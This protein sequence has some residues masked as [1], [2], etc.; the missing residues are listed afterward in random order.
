M[1]VHLAPLGAAVLPDATPAALKYALC[2]LGLASP[3]VRLPL[4]ELDQPDKMTVAKAVAGVFLSCRGCDGEHH[5]LLA[6]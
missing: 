6:V 1:A 2:L 3:S 4:V 5:D